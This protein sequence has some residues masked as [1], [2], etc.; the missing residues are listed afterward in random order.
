MLMNES[1]RRC[2]TSVGTRIEGSTSRTSN[3]ADQLEDPADRPRGGG[4]PLQPPRPLDEARV[5]H[6]GWGRRRRTMR[7]S[8]QCST[9]SPSGVPHL[10]RPGQLVAGRPGGPG[11]GGVEHQRADALRVGGREQRRHRAALER[12]GDAPPARSR[13]RP[14]PRSRRPSAPRAWARRRTGPTGRSRADRS[15]H[16]GEAG[17]PVASRAR[18]SGSDQRYSTCEIQG[19]IQT[20][21]MGPSP[22]TMYAIWRSPLLA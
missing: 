4:E 19:G 7:P 8:P 3:L 14:S 9:C 16:A 13:R 5:V 11:E 15:D 21:S 2:I 6:L 20:R 12:A 17:Q 10:G 18:A 1:S 22:S